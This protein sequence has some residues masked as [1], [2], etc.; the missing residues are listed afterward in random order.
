MLVRLPIN[1]KWNGRRKGRKEERERHSRGRRGGAGRR[2]GSGKAGEA[3]DELQGEG[4]RGAGRRRRRRIGLYKPCL[5][6]GSTRAIF[7]LKDMLSLT[8][9]FKNTIML[10]ICT[11]TYVPPFAE[12]NSG[13]SE[14]RSD[15]CEVVI[16]VCTMPST[17]RL[18]GKVCFQLD[19]PQTERLLHLQLQNGWAPLLMVVPVFLDWRNTQGG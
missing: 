15:Y 16:P 6:H 9:V 18:N 3:W 5:V 13:Q 12:L 4:E 19:V 17:V 2:G 1:K 11:L 10:P 8:V 7:A 14:R